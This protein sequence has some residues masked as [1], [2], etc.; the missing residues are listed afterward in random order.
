MSQGR[1]KKTKEAVSQ[2]SAADLRADMENVDVYFTWVFVLLW[3]FATLAM[4]A[5][6]SLAIFQRCVCQSQGVL[7]R[8]SCLV[9]VSNNLLPV[10]QG[11]DITARDPTTFCASV[12]HFFET[13]KMFN[14][15]K[16][17]GRPWGLVKGHDDREY[18]R[19]DTYAHF[20]CIQNDEVVQTSELTN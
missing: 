20:M 18:D 17:T 9:D 5:G 2:P 13:I 7:S 16:S 19:K 11:L 1:H 15:F 6:S 14:K 3:T 10:L 8:N 12:I 4:L